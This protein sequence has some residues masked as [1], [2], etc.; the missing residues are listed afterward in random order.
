[1]KQE[2]NLGKLNDTA[3]LATFIFKEAAYT[4]TR[5]EYF[6]SWTLVL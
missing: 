2:D 5:F 3:F 6:V 1:M 4:Y